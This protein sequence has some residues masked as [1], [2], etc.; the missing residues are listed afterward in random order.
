MDELKIN[1]VSELVR[2]A[3][4]KLIKRE[5][6]KKL[7]YD[8]DMSLNEFKFKIENGK[9]NVHVNIDASMNSDELIGTL[10]ER[11]ISE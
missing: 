7:G 4:T 11:S 10:I 8:V 3:I 1:L 5:I 9:A 2:K 6:V